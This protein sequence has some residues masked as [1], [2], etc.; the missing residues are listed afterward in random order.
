M[1][2]G[3]L[4]VVY[5]GRPRASHNIDFVVE[6]PKQ[7]I[8]RVLQVLKPL[9]TEFLFQEDAI[10]QAIKKEDMFNIIYLPTYLKLGFWLL[11]DD[12]FDQE[13]FK[14]RQK[15]RLL[16]ESMWISSPEDTILQKLRWYKKAKIE[17][18]IID[19]AFVYQ[20]Q[21]KKL[22]KKYLKHWSKKLKVE[23]FLKQLAK[24]NLEL[25]L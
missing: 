25:Y 11:T 17:K 22:D 20:I 8:E 24:I 14:R 21:K 4:S 1:L 16:N 15:I 19:A 13:R 3:A 7:D 18:H 5:Y 6:I 23:K 12:L 9:S 2:T 10:E